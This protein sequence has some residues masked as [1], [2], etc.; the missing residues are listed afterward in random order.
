MQDPTILSVV[1]RLDEIVPRL[2]TVRD[3]VEEIV[4]GFK[5]S[6][7][8]DDFHVTLAYAEVPPENLH[9]LTKRVREV[10]SSEFWPMKLHLGP[11]DHLVNKE[12]ETVIHIS[13]KS[14]HIMRLAKR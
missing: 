7:E 1:L 9:S 4:G 6:T 2:W 5:E 8:D 13:V 10:I 12:N 14:L 11:V 3:R